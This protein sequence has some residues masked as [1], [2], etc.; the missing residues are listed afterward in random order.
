MNELEPAEA[1]TEFVATTGRRVQHALMAHLGP[2]VGDDVAAEVLEYA[3]EHWDRV[4]QMENPA[5]YLFTIGRRRGHRARSRPRLLARPSSSP[6]APWVEPGLEPALAALTTRQRTAVLLVHG[7]GWTP[8]EVAEV[9]GVDR[10]TVARHAE[11]ALV[12][13]RHALE[14]TADA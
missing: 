4:R 2:D 11:R 10:G 3:W 9:L 13:L 14:V 6:S 8:S 5:G 12:R 1:F 7:A